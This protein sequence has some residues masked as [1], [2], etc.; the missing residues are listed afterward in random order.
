VGKSSFINA[1]LGAR[2]W[3]KPAPRR[4]DAPAELLSGALFAPDGEGE[5][6]EGYLHFVDLPGMDSPR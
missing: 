5:E 1:L 3:P 6:Q 4:Q 2:P